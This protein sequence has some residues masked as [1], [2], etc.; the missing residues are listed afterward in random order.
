MHAVLHSQINRRSLAITDTCN[1]DQKVA[2]FQA[3][4]TDEGWDPW[5]LVFLMLIRLFCM[6]KATGEVWDPWRLVILVLI[7]LFSMHKFGRWGLGPIES[8][9]SGHNVTV[10]T[11]QNHRW[12]LGPIE[13]S[14]SGAKVVVLN[15]KN[16]RWGLGPIETCNSD[17]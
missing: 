6:H 5:R 16:H 15:A 8:I 9:N 2:V 13:T 14:N 17:P 7:T 1:S 3:K 10:V 11:A 12:R 4:T